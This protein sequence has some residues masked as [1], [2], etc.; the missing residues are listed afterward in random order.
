MADYGV[1]D[2]GF[3]RKPK[4]VIISELQ[5]LLKATFGQDL[6]VS[7]ESPEGQIISVIADTVD[8]LWEVAEHS[9]NA[10]NPNA[11]SNIT[12]ENLVKINNLTRKAATASTVLIKY[13]G[14]DGTVIPLGSTVSSNSSLTGG[15][16]YKFD[17]ESSGIIVGGTF[18]VLAIAQETGAVQVPIGSITV[19]DTPIVGITS[20]TNEAVGN[21]GT[22][23][24]TD[25]QL[26][27][28]R[29]SEVALPAMA[30]L[31]AIVASIQNIDTVLSVKAYENDTVSE[32]TEGGVV[33]P[34]HG[35]KI[36]VQGSETEEENLAIASAIYL[37][38]D[39]G[40]QTS[41]DVIYTLQDS[42]GFDKVIKWTTPTIVPIYIDIVTDATSLTA[43]DSSGDVIRDAIMAFIENSVTG[44]TIGDVVSYARLFTPI[45]SIPDHN[46]QS[47][48][49]GIVPSP[50]GMVDIG[51]DGGSLASIVDPDNDITVTINYPS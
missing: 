51:I 25:P 9:Y 31:D 33:I 10:F 46:V 17:T 42:Q 7:A 41:G 40:I 34:P 48:K 30:T 18:E 23:E 21:V 24:E 12:L 44:Y 37:K 3:K 4:T 38:K 13:T 49:I 35:L 27:S 1:L 5:E 20:V 15:I 43:L 26:R 29:E 11:A 6:D 45:N 14:V 19:I 8:P 2:T 28:R 36:I 50:T 47:L 16:S 22:D 32:I 39:P